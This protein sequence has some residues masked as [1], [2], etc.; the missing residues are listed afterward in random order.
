MNFL[1]RWQSLLI[2]I[3]LSVAFA[4]A[5]ALLT[6]LDDW[7]F[8]LNQPSWKPPD[9]AFGLIWSIIFSLSAAAAWLSWNSA[10]NQKRRMIY[11]S[12]YLINGLLNVLWSFLYFNLHRPDW[13][14]IECVLLWLS[15]LSLIISQFRDSR[16]SSL[17]VIPYLI[18]VSIAM[19]LNWQ[20]IVLNGF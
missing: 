8:S 5:G 7:Y 11:L 4:S 1:R 13:S 2:C 14:L 17:L 3:F 6:T 15:V 19:T 10:K 12:L 16:T 9:P 20:T 18:W